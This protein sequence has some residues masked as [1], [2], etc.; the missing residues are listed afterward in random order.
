M[1]SFQLLRHVALTLLLNHRLQCLPR[2]RRLL[3]L[4]CRRLLRQLRLL[5]TFHQAT[6]AVGALRKTTAEILHQERGRV[7]DRALRMEMRQLHEI[8]CAKYVTM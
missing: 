7:Q 3:I 8:G 4:P 2:T 5:R 1:D 6:K